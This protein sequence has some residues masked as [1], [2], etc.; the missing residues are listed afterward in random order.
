ML[1]PIEP[2]QAVMAYDENQ[3]AVALRYHDQSMEE[4]L[5][6]FRWLRL[7]TYQLIQSLP[8]SVWTQTLEHPENGTMSLEDWL[9]VYERH[10]P[11][12]IEQ[13]KDVYAAWL[14]HRSKT[15]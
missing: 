3:W 2:G 9:D 8:D 14:G 15:I 7:R 5:D 1:N 12:H 10:I 11:H 4:A 6:L 13:M